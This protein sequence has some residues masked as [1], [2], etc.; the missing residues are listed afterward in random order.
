MQTQRAIAQTKVSSLIQVPGPDPHPEVS[1][2]LVRPLTS[3]GHFCCLTV[4]FSKHDPKLILVAL[5]QCV[6]I[7][8][9]VESEAQNPLFQCICAIMS[10]SLLPFSS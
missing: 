9:A 8:V 1:L 10:K 3:K 5:Q 4:V 7:R 2:Q 6:Y